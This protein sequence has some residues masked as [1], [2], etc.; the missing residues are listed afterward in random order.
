MQ[1]ILLTLIILVASNLAQAAK[2]IQVDLILFAHQQTPSM[3]R[4][5]IHKMPIAKTKAITLSPDNHS[6]P[7]LKSSASSLNNEYYRLTH[8]KAYKALAHY[9]WRQPAANQT[10]VTLPPIHQKGWDIEG[11]LLVKKS[12]YYLFDAQLSF[13]PP[14]NPQSVF[15]LKQKQG[16]QKGTVYYFDHPQLGMILKIHQ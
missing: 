8:H 13:S 14:Y 15:T 12:N 10:P 5:S 16:I 11:V 4:Q 3:Q 1:K 9:S 7:L 2:S 6:Y